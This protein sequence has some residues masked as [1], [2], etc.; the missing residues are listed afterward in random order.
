[1]ARV[2]RFGKRQAEFRAGYYHSPSVCRRAPAM[3]AAFAAAVVA[4][5]LSFGRLFT[6][7]LVSI[8]FCAAG[9]FIIGLLCCLF[10][11]CFFFPATIPTSVR[12][13]WSKNQDEQ[14]W[15]QYEKKTLHNYGVERAN[16]TGKRKSCCGR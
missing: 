13:T 5:A 3:T 7:P 6:T 4:T 10:G 16:I 12:P 15:K 8:A 14:N 2:Y 11:S 9:L 1:M